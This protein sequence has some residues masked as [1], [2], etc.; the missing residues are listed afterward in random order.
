MLGGRSGEICSSSVDRSR[1]HRL[2]RP[3]WTVHM[4]NSVW[5]DTDAIYIYD[6]I[7][8]RVVWVGKRVIHDEHLFSIRR[9]S[10]RV[11]PRGGSSDRLICRQNRI[12]NTLLP[13][14]QWIAGGSIPNS[15]GR[16]SSIVGRIGHIV[17]SFMTK[18]CGTFI[19]T[20]VGPVH[21]LP[22]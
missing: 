12:G 20:I 16:E 8:R 4:Q 9:L 10:D 15:V 17:G 7:H 21:P 5:R 3:G 14:P 22:G 19:A 2:R 11:M 6:A 1:W 13:W 18:N